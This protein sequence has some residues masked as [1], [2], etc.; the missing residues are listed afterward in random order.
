MGLWNDYLCK[1][2]EPG[3]SLST[4]LTTGRTFQ[5]I[6]SRKQPF[7]DKVTDA[8]VMF[9]IIHGNLPQYERQEGVEAYSAMVEDQLTALCRQCWAMGPHDRSERWLFC[10]RILVDTEL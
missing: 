10:A 8:Q 4:R 3:A 2:V 9:A 6:V 5:E 1:C 7:H